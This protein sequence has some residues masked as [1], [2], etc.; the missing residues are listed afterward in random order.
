MHLR[1]RKF[2]SF[3]KHLSAETQVAGSRNVEPVK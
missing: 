2:F 3:K 1:N